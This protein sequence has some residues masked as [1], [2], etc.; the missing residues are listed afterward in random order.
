MKDKQNDASTQVETVFRFLTGTKPRG[1]TPI[2]FLFCMLLSV[3]TFISCKDEENGNRGHDPNKPIALTTFSPDSGR[4]SEMVLL[5]GENFGTDPSQVK[6]FF[7]TK[8]AA[9]IN[10][11]GSRI[12]ALVPRLPGDTC[13][14]SV[15]IGDQRKEYADPFRYKIAASVT[16]LAGN[17]NNPGD[18]PDYSVG[19]DRILLRPVYIGIDKDFNIFVSIR[20]GNLLRLNVAENSATVVATAVQGYS[21]R[22]AP[23][24]NP[25]TNVLQTGAEGDENRDRFCFMDP[26]T[27][28]IPKLYFIKEWDRGLNTSTGKEYDLPTNGTHYH[29]LLCEADG[30]YYTRYNSG[31][32][33]RIDPKTWKATIVGMTPSGTAYGAAMHPINTTEFWFAYG[34]GDGGNNLNSLCKV[35][36]TDSTVGSDGV[37]L[38]SFT[39]LSG[40]INGGHRDGPLSTAQF[41]N[42]RGISFDSDGNLYIGDSQNRCIRMVNTTTMMV[43]TM[44]GIP[45][46]SGF[47]DGSKDDA[48]FNDPHG[49]VVD[50]EDIIYVSDYSNF[51]IR[52]IAIE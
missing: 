49:L 15:E 48:L 30:N 40:A 33:V 28:W 52:R 45:E 9:V 27:G 35:D 41:K 16:T 24:A 14:L 17:G 7:N 6:V 26:K 2:L 8:E 44:I 31:E 38:A 29:C 3:I 50:A 42:P 18:N 21:L 36:V 13:V 4:I 51:R 1:K 39:K 32:L 20:D 43:E 5:D 11:T 23:I 37:N 46:Q 25:Q 10:S 34:E 47:K 22:C 12:L 19:L